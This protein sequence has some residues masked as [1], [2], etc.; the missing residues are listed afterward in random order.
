MGI[1][2]S[3]ISYSKL[4]GNYNRATGDIVLRDII[5]YSKLS[6]NYNLHL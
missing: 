3:I 4:S 1:L 2:V 5:S 6:G